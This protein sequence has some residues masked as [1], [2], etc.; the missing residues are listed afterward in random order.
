MN[1]L[2]GITSYE[3]QSSPSMCFCLLFRSYLFDSKT[4][5]G[6]ESRTFLV[7]RPFISYRPFEI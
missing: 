7:D 1:R 4:L 3:F 2:N 6:N 5:N